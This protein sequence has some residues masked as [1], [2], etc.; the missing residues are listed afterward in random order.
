MTETQNPFATT[1][2]NERYGVQESNGLVDGGA[3]HASVDYT[4][5]YSLAQV[6]EEGGKI[7]RVRM[8]A[9]R[10]LVDISYIHATLRDGRTVP[11][12]V[13]GAYSYLIPMNRIKSTFIEW[14]KE[15]HVFAK[16]LGLLDE[17][18]WSILR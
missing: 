9:E 14:A 3:Y 10:G 6:A 8:L 18:N 13:D 7:T 17:G 5:A 16:G 1:D 15:Q 11:V 4:D 12:R 2:R